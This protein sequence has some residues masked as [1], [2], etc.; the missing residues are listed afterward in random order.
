MEAGN[1]PSVHITPR[2]L[3]T[4][5]ADFILY[6]LVGPLMIAIRFNILLRGDKPTIIY[7]QGGTLRLNKHGGAYKNN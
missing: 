4:L 3:S 2:L 7:C 1:V 6:L 5:I